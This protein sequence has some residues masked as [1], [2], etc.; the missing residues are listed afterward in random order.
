MQRVVTLQAA[1]DKALD[2]LG[3][4]ND[5]YPAPVANAGRILDDT[6]RNPGAPSI[7]WTD[8][9]IPPAGFEDEWATIQRDKGIKVVPDDEHGWRHG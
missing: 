7:P 9:T 6:R 3:V 8:G 2:E 4:P 5:G 1:I